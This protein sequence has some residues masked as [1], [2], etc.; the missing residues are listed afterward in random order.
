MAAYRY[1]AV[2]SH[3]LEQ[4]WFF[5][6]QKEKGEQE[7]GRLQGGRHEHGAGEAAA[8]AHW[9]DGRW[10]VGPAVAGGIGQAVWHGQQAR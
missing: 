4:G 10:G 9:R 7:Y 3:P 5:A 8:A 2:K 6:A 1:G